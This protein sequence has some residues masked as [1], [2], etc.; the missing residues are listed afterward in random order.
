MSVH[1]I[2]A[3]GA[4]RPEMGTGFP[5]NGIGDGCEPSC[6]CWELNPSLVREQY[7][8]LAVEHLSSPVVL[9]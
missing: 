6:R 4:Q 7:V 9:M 1:H 2:L 3:W 5:R 8:I